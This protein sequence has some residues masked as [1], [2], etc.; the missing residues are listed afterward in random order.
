MIDVVNTNNFFPRLEEF[1]NLDLRSA[2]AELVWLKWTR[3][4]WQEK[5]TVADL[6]QLNNR[7][8]FL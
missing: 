8:I 7:K 3:I 1:S 2:E 5:G 4:S 6:Y